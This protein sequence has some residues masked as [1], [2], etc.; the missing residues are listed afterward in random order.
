MAWRLGDLLLLFTTGDKRANDFSEALLHHVVALF[1]VLGSYLANIMPMGSLIM[2]YHDVC[3]IFSSGVRVLG[4]SD[5]N[6]SNITLFVYISFLA[7]WMHLRVFLL[8][9]L[10]YQIYIKAEIGSPAF[11]HSKVITQL[12]TAFLS[13]LYTMHLY[14]TYILL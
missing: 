1:L 4:D 6:G 5:Y 2:V 12:F 14:W 3:D 13:V 8:P 7:A 11:E 10:V 9:Q